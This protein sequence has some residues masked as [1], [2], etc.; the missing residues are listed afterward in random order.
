MDQSRHTLDEFNSVSTWL[1]T[2][3]L[4]RRSTAIMR[5]TLPPLP[6]SSANWNYAS[7]QTGK[8]PSRKKRTR[9]AE[10]VTLTLIKLET[11]LLDVGVQVS[12]FFFPTVR[13]VGS[14]THSLHGFS[15]LLDIGLWVKTS[16]LLHCSTVSN[17]KILFAFI[18]RYFLQINHSKRR[19]FL[20]A[21]RCVRC[22]VLLYSCWPLPLF[23]FIYC[24]YIYIKFI[25]KSQCPFKRLKGQS[26]E[27]RIWVFSHSLL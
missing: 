22:C 21:I 15:Q 4:L 24:I 2:T 27:G 20:H 25:F 11:Y 5:L 19:H 9:T 13:L 12:I 17:L 10:N 1:S 14:L 26:P 7:A 3:F 6:A 23:Y 18:A 16:G 8:S